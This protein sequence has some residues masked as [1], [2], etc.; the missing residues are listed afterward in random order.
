MHCRSPGLGHPGA[1]FKMRAKSRFS[2]LPQAHAGKSGIHS[3]A[4][5]LSPGICR[6]SIGKT[7]HRGDPSSLGGRK[8]YISSGTEKTGS[9]GWLSPRWLQDAEEL[10]PVHPVVGKK[11][12]LKGV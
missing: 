8:W 2:S 5:A 12:K 6:E 11:T 1:S 4:A 7:A 3:G 10:T 9:P